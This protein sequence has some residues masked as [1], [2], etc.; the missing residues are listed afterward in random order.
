MWVQLKSI[1]YLEVQ[2][3]LVTYHPGDWI[4]VGKQMAQ[5]WLSRGEAIIPQREE[6]K[7]LGISPGSGVV[8][9]TEEEPGKAHEAA[10]KM[11][12]PYSG[13]QVFVSVVPLLAYDRTVI[14]KSGVKFRV[15]MIPVGL[16]LL[17]KWELAIPILDYDNIASKVGSQAERDKTRELLHD[18]RVPLY[19]TRLMFAKRCKNTTTLFD[20]WQ[21]EVAGGAE[22]RH[23]F[24]RSLYQTP[25]LVL[26]LP[27]TWTNQNVR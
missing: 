19:D 25:M 18:D 6:Y 1:Q 11:L 2:G 21:Q 16:S 9:I 17:D 7:Q 14:I 4:N 10:K 15:D 8:L 23:A 22:E 27:V 20:R 24:L 5:L 12:L 3:K 26:A 13:I